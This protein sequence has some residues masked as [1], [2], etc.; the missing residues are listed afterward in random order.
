MTRP[1]E[2]DAWTAKKIEFTGILA[3]GLA[4]HT[5]LV[6]PTTIGNKISF[7]KSRHFGKARQE[8]MKVNSTS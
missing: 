5:C 1:L 7:D 8:R 4:L 3:K 2:L 6:V